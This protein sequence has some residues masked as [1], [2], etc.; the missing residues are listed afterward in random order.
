MKILV[1]GDKHLGL[2]SDGLNRLEEQRTILDACIDL[3]RSETPKV[4]V[5]LGDLFDSPR[6]SPAT[7]ALAVYYATQIAEWRAGDV[8]RRAYILAGNHDKPTRGHDHAL[9]PLVVL[10]QSDPIFPSIVIDPITIEDLLFLPYVTPWES[11]QLGHDSAQDYFDVVSGRDMP[12][13]SDLGVCTVFCH[14]N[15]AG[16]TVGEDRVYRDVGLTIPQSLI[17]SQ[18]VKKIY[19]GH[20]H[21]HQNVGKVSIVGSSIF[22][23]FGEAFDTKGAIVA[24]V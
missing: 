2:V 5:D 17:E 1:T 3:L 19:G 12:T 22:C 9:A 13:A 4:Y 7:M 6:P 14:C 15:V 23:N 18:S 21:K 11:K 20:I 8:S 24:E 10:N 16:A